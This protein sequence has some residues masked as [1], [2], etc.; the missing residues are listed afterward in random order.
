M[1]LPTKT[2]HPVRLFDLSI[3]DMEAR[4]LGVLDFPSLADAAT[5][6]GVSP[7]TVRNNQIEKRA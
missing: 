4:R 7:S 3:P 5:F 2:P 6:L 1:Y